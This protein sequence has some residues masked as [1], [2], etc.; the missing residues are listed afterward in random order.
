MGA[1]TI[2]ICAVGDV[3]AIFSKVIAAHISGYLN[4]S[5][6]LLPPVGHPEYALE[7]SR[8]QYD[9]AHILSQLNG[10]QA[11]HC[12]KIIGIVGVDLFI[13]IFT[14]VFGEAC[15]GGRVALVSTYRLSERPR[16]D[17]PIT[18]L[19]LERTAKV[20]LHELGHL[21]NLTHCHDPHCLMHFSGD[22]IDLDRTRFAFCR[23]C[24]A[25][26]RDAVEG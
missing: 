21:F 13:P 16:N 1:A 20:A 24:K 15:Q 22:L 14:H 3:D 5:T 2:G 11:S 17:P 25:Y 7:Q 19:V 26:I 18:A 23:Y 12:S 6:R 10:L 9:A 8:M 4:L